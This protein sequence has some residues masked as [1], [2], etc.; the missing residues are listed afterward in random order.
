LE[1]TDYKKLASRDVNN[2]VAVKLD[3]SV[4]G[5]GIFAE[6]SLSKN[7][8]GTVVYRAVAQH[9][10]SGTPI[11]S[12]ILGCKNIFDFCTVRRVTGGAVWRGVLLGKAIRFY[13]STDG[14]VITYAKNGNRVPNSEGTM[15]MMDAL[16][17]FPK[18]VDYQFY[19]D[20]AAK[21][22]KEVGYA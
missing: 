6:P 3:G 4:K 7:P 17:E 20:K 15:P 10:A 8:D 1:R 21:L 14:D 2:Y 18:D 13:H 12:T 11:E 5:K 19:L 9:I 16:T 22:L